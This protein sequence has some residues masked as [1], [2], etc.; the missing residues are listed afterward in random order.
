MKAFCRLLAVSAAA[1]TLIALTGGTR[2]QLLITGNDGA[3][4]ETPDIA[5][6]EECQVPRGNGGMI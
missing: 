6:T 3:H 2:A 4:P 5:P 1:S